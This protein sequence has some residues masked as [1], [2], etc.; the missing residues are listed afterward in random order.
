MIIEIRRHGRGGQGARTASR[1]LSVAALKQGYH[2]QS[3]PT[4]GPERMGAPMEAYNRIADE[5]IEIHSGVY[6][7][8]H[9]IV[10]D[11]TLLSVVD[12]L[13]GLKPNGTLTV[14]TPKTPQEVRE[15]LKVPESI[16][17][18]T[19]NAT[20]LALEILGRPITN[21]AMIGAR[22]RVSGVLPLEAIIEAIKEVFPPKIAEKNVELVKRAYNEVML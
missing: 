15:M 20:R 1:I 4:F 12:V 5:K 16:K 21:T 14:N 19:I 18:G 8:D 6:E 13:R 11:D 9:V 22:A 2:I 7:P 17:I 10:L 3:F